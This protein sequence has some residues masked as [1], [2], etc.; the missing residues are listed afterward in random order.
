MNP[1]YLLIK[2]LFV[3]TIATSFVGRCVHAADVYITAEFN[4]DLSNPQKNEFTNTTPWSG[5]CLQNHIDVCKSNNWWS[6]ATGIKGT[7]KVV[8]ADIPGRGA[9]HI[10]FP[11]KRRLIVRSL[12]NHE[13]PL[14]LI[15][16]GAALRLKDRTLT[17]ADPTFDY[18]PIPTAA[19]K[20]ALS[21][22]AAGNYSV[23]RMYLRKDN[24][25]SSLGCS[26]SSLATP[27][28]AM[29]YSIEDFDVVYR[30]ITPSPLEML[31]G[32]Y[33]GSVTYSVGGSLANDFDLGNG[34]NPNDTSLTLHFHIKV[35]HA[36]YVEFIAPHMRA[37]LQ[38]DGGWTQW[39]DYGR[40]PSRLTQEIPFNISSS[41]VFKI[42]LDCEYPQPDGRC[43]IA[44]TTNT[45]QVVPVD[46]SVSMPGIIEE[47]THRPA[48]NTALNVS[49]TEFSTDHLIVRSKRSYLNFKVQNQT[50]ITQMLNTPG[51]LYKGNVRVIFD[52][53]ID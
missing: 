16:T 19:C 50:D 35:K 34:A 7:K 24:G 2:I 11:G 8:P 45:R 44:D 33:E 30:M 47:S 40:I 23:M 1:A 6:I 46:V 43:A 14:D 5:V 18:N 17:H 28:L 20:Q 27:L 31:P 21:N 41:S 13:Y 3:G 22:N 12:E 53:G 36:F 32:E 29:P 26:T 42:S 9:F 48:A 37:I 38:L 25:E 49:P 52:A 15:I 4:A 39:T 51:K 10:G